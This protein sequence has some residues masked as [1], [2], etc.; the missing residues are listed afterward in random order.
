MR[1][2]RLNQ[3]AVYDYMVNNEINQFTDD[4]ARYAVNHISVDWNANALE[5]AQYYNNKYNIDKQILYRILVS[6]N[7]ER[8][9][10]EQAQ[11]A[12]DNLQ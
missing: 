8:Y 1:Q 4:E 9:T 6:K 12:I 5:N 3:R 11:Y 7:G 2:K 10:A